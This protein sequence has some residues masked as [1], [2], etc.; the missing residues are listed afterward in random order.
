MTRFLTDADLTYTATADV[1][2]GADYALLEHVHPTLPDKAQIWKPAGDRRPTRHP[3]RV[4]VLDTVT[5]PSTT[6]P[7]LLIEAI[8]RI[9]N[10]GIHWFR[11]DAVWLRDTRWVRRDFGSLEPGVQ[12]AVRSVGPR[13]E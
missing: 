8:D 5:I 12:A 1:E 3:R 13:W 2:H 4:T 10:P 6:G 11:E 7:W 9:Q